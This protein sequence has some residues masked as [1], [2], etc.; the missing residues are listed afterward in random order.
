[1]R[2]IIKNAMILFVIALISSVLLA[3]SYSITKEPIAKQQLIRQNEALSAVLPDSEFTEITE[4]D[5]SKQP[6]ILSLFEAK[7]GSDIVG[8]A[9]KVASEEG[10]S[11][12]L[13]LVV[14]ISP[15][16]KLTGIDLVQQSETP[17][18][19]AKSDDEEFKSQYV[20]K[21]ASL[22]TVVKSAPA[23]ESEIGAISGATITSR[24]VTN[25]VNEAISYFNEN[26]AEGV[27]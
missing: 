14:G 19:G 12:H 13:E 11:G 24:A 16:G 5:F 7:S 2:D 15:D 9:F 8:Y 6:A 22:L 3:F 1:M 17:G 4:A 21:P 26:L 10:Y 20:Q 25:A 27:K 18:L 23:N